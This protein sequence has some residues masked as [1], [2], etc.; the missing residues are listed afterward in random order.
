[1]NGGRS[2][3]SPAPA[4]DASWA[5]P[6]RLAGRDRFLARFVAPFGDTL[7]EA[8]EHDAAVAPEPDRLRGFPELERVEV[9]L[10]DGPVQ[11]DVRH[12]RE[13][14]AEREEEVGLLRVLPRLGR[15]EVAEDPDHEL[16]LLGEAALRTERGQDRSRKPF[17]ERVDERTVSV[18]APAGQEYGPLGLPE[19]L[20]SP[21]EGRR[22]RSDRGLGQAGRARAVR[23]VERELLDVVRD[24]ELRDTVV[25]QGVLDAA[26]TIGT[27]FAWSWIVAL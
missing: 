21:V 18:R 25:D 11:G 17:R 24:R 2:G 7:E 26:V 5:G 4:S 12:L 16:G 8:R 23:G 20:D 22:G 3:V 27:A 14:D 9:D 6:P 10:D 1:M 13:P 19:R 15:P